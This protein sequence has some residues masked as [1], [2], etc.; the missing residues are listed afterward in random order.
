MRLHKGDFDQLTH[1]S[2]DPVAGATAA[3]VGPHGFTLSI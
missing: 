3:A 1:Y 2:S